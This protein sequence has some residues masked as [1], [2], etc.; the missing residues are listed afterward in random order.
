[1]AAYFTMCLS[2]ALEVNRI[3]YQVGLRSG[4]TAH[5]VVDP[6]AW[7]TGTGSVN[8]TGMRIVGSGD[9]VNILFILFALFLM[10]L[11]H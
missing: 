8:V 7:V 5:A 3:C 11:V 4:H 2:S 10:H 9:G 6:H 1:M